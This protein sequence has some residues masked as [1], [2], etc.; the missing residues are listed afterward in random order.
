MK[1]QHLLTPTIIPISVASLISANAANA[2]IHYF[3]SSHSFAVS[4]YG[5]SSLYWDIESGGSTSSTGA[6]LLVQ[7]FGGYGSWFRVYSCKNSFKFVFS[8]GNGI[9]ALGTDI[10][11]S[12]KL[13]APL[14][15]KSL[16]GVLVVSNALINVVGFTDNTAKYIGFTFKNSS[17]ITCYGWASITLSYSADCVII[18][19]WAYNDNGSAITVGAISVPEPAQTATGLGALALGAAGLARWRKSKQ[20]KAA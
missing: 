13:A 18:N 8:S 9:K 20:V 15:F 2:S 1:K 12:S 17:G 11:I 7:K 14:S 3:D 4:K 10:T 16:V 5:N 6:E 19:E